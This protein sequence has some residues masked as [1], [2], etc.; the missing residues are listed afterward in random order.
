[1][2]KDKTQIDKFREAAKAIEAVTDD[3]YDAAVAKVAKAPKLTD[4]EIKELARKRRKAQY[5]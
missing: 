4:D 3:D 2:A 5:G 1:M